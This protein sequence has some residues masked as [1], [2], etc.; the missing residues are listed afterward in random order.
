MKKTIKKI[1]AVLSA[2]ATL[3]VTTLSAY[4][5]DNGI[6]KYDID[7]KS[8]TSL[9]DSY[10]DK[11]AYEDELIAYLNALRAKTFTSEETANLHEYVH[12]YNYSKNP[13]DD[14]THRSYVVEER[15]NDNSRFFSTTDICWDGS[16]YCN[17]DELV[18][19]YTIEEMNEFLKNQGFKSHLTEA[20]HNGKKVYIM[21]NDDKSEENVVG[22]FLALNKKYDAELPFSKLVT[23]TEYHEGSGNESSEN[24]IIDWAQYDLNNQAYID[25]VKSLTPIEPETEKKL[26]AMLRDVS[27]PGD[28]IHV[29]RKYANGGPYVREF[30]NVYNP[31]TGNKN[32][33]S[34]ADIAVC[35]DYVCFVDDT[36]VSVDE[37]N[38]FLSENEFNAVAAEEVSGF[39]PELGYTAN[40]HI[41]YDESI[42][43]DHKIDILY[44]LYE[45]FGLCFS[46]FQLV[47]SGITFEDESAEP[48]E[49]QTTEPAVN[50]EETATSE[51]AAQTETAAAEATLKG[52]ADLNGEVGVADVIKV[53]KYNLSNLMFPL[54]D[55]K[56]MA[57]A[58]MNCDGVVD[59]V[60]CNMLIELNLGN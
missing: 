59:S 29:Y 33:R 46:S 57:N 15:R 9:V 1:L 31:V 25:Y 35:E 30:A 19:K 37:V 51:A 22:A 23:L 40:F 54:T 21:N 50:D 26:I 8:Y 20:T 48:D 41:E 24:G 2:A 55:S 36:H 43:V 28:L 7:N 12:I 38:D 14:I 6:A 58:D 56:A 10:G 3:G 5:T 34:F 16:S 32:C 4:A 49:P 52:D 17:N 60:D 42:D 39:V 18:E 45:N 53:S 47:S 44:A 27:S 13:D 11:I